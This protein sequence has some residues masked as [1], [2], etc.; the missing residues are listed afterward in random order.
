MAER[1]RAVG[2]LLLAACWLVPGLLP[3]PTVAHEL[4]TARLSFVDEGAGAYRLTAKT[5]PAVVVDAPD[6]PDACA[7]VDAARRPAVGAL[8]IHEWLIDC[9]GA[10]PADD[11][12]IGLALGVEDALVV[13]RNQDGVE[14]SFQLRSQAGRIVLPIA[15]SLAEGQGLLELAGRQL[16]LGVAHILSGA[17]HLA[18]LV[19][20]CLVASGWGLVRLVTGF[21]I[22]HSLT[23]A[24]ATLG[25]VNLPGLL[26]EAWIALSIAFLAR[27]VLLGDRSPVPGFWLVVGF[28]LLHGLGFAGALADLGLPTGALVVALLGFN[29][30]VEIGQLLFVGVLVMALHAL[31]R[32]QVGLSPVRRTAG[33]A[34]GAAAVFWTIERVV[35]FAA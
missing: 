15:A 3:A 12:A 28:G 19:C 18:L 17:D 2:A 14:H 22:G 30:G 31:G 16:D 4:A 6:V 21:T 23:L 26:I 35:Q 29:L 33:F 5:G 8:Q 27:Q 7:I 24:L 10:A 25:W 13:T 11:A 20:L 9:G 1:R 34:L 32:L